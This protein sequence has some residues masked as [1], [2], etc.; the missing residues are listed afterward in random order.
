MKYHPHILV[1]DDDTRLRDLISQYLTENEF[2]VTTAANSEEARNRLRGLQ[3]DLLVVDVMMP[4]EG[5]LELTR[6]LRQL[7]NVPI[8]LLTAMG[9]PEDRIRGLEFGADDYVTK[10]FEPRELVLRIK[11]ILG[12]TAVEAKSSYVALGE[13]QFHINRRELRKDDKIV[14]LTTIEANLL[15]ALAQNPGNPMTR[16]QLI[17]QC[18]IAGTARTVDVQVTRLRRKIERNPREPHF[19]HTV[20]GHGYVLHPD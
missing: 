5:G 4:G 3:F 15:W 12:R 7:S 20:R 11:S 16:E 10:P 1:I 13:C 2:R 17:D 8:L 9:E 19:L 6:S 14:R 18:Q